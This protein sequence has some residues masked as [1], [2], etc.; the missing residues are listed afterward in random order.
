MA[1]AE[2]TSTRGTVLKGRS[3]RKVEPLFQSHRKAEGPGEGTCIEP[4]S[5]NFLSLSV[6]S[7][8]LI[9]ESSVAS[10]EGKLN[11]NN[12]FPYEGPLLGTG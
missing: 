5:S 10:Q 6:G 2:V 3:I 9:L 7:I 4:G 11:I 8:G 1:E 12:V